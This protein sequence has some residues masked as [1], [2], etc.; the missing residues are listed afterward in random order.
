MPASAEIYRCVDIGIVRRYTYE[1]RYG[2]D[3]GL[4]LQLS[5][6]DRRGLVATD[7]A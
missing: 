3:L 1:N 7:A 2:S 6:Q 5:Y 4:R